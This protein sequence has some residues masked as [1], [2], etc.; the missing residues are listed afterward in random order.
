MEENRIF[1]QLVNYAIAYS[2]KRNPD[3][4]TGY[5]IDNITLQDK[6]RLLWYAIQSYDA[7]ADDENLREMIITSASKGN[8]RNTKL[9]D[10]LQSYFESALIN[11]KPMKAECIT[12]EDTMRML[13]YVLKQYN[14]LWNDKDFLQGVALFS[15]IKPT[16]NLA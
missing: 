6:E 4:T 15:R 9:N 10:F 16:C 13:E 8:Q 12:E 1:K 5:S 2:G 7:I 14:V 3:I 11:K